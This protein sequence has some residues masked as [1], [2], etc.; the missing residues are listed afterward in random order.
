M[1]TRQI[2]STTDKNRIKAIAEFIKS[3]GFSPNITAHD[4]VAFNVP[5][6]NGDTGEDGTA[7]YDVANWS[8]ARA[9]LGY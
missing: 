2:H 4:S 9:A 3:H 7:S 5:T 1:E 6:Y 8:Q